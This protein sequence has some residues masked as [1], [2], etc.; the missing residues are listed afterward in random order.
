MLR[1]AENNNPGHEKKV[2]G[3]QFA[4]CWHHISTNR[5]V[6]M[7]SA[8]KSAYNGLVLQLSLWARMEGGL[9]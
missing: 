5:V 8:T 6:S 2:G 7:L 1:V 4:A 3:Q 9:M